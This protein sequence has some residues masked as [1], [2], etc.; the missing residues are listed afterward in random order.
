MMS[1]G[2]H[3]LFEQGRALADQNKY[4]E[5]A[6][7]FEK[8]AQSYA[9][10]GLAEE[11]RKS[12]GFAF[13][14]KAVALLDRGEYAASVRATSIAIP[15]L[16]QVAPFEQSLLRAIENLSRSELQIA[17]GDLIGAQ[18][19]YGEARRWAE[20]AKT[21]D[22]DRASLAIMVARLALL[23]ELTTRLVWC[24]IRKEW[25]QVVVSKDRAVAI[26]R[27][28]SAEP[29]ALQFRETFLARARYLEGLT[30][31][32]RGANFLGR[33]HIDEAK[34]WLAEASVAFADAEAV[35]VS[36]A[37][38]HPLYRQH[39]QFTRGFKI[40]SDAYL[41]Y[42]TALEQLPVAGSTDAALSAL[43][44]ASGLCRNAQRIFD[45]MGPAGRALWRVVEEIDDAVTA[46]EQRVL[47]VA[48]AQP[49]PT[50]QTSIVISLAQINQL[51]EAK[52]GVPLFQ[53]PEPRF[54][55][56][57]YEPCR[58]E[59]EFQAKVAAL[60]GVF[61]RID[62]ASIIAALPKAPENP[63]S[64]NALE[65]VLAYWGKDGKTLVAPFRTL[66]VLRKQ[67]PIH[68]DFKEVAEAYKQ[69]GV[70]FPIDDYHAGWQAVLRV[71]DSAL[72]MLRA[73]LA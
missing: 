21:L 68:E 23:G 33:W 53:F 9:T 67:Y 49:K 41:E 11:A 56:E 13:G 62:T 18:R 30:A 31:L 47:G 12:R 72:K 46:L 32:F 17:S 8:A 59:A 22:P 65:A 57:L 70:P 35:A 3:E 6:A 71:L 42:G 52:C 55:R 1:K 7:V 2:A 25:D 50:Q 4:D 54:F 44:R 16:D 15:L 19:T 66:R 5:A 51:W 28:L 37:S 34:D 29:Q 40:L 27:L 60:A 73:A 26:C 69:I 48:L 36:A 64:I 38:D 61:D 39:L 58:T 43:V 63:G 45:R 20:Q 10:L 14:A 24:A